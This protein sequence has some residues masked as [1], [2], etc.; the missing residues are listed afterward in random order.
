MQPLSAARQRLRDLG[1]MAHTRGAPAALAFGARWATFP[2]WGRLAR[3]RGRSFALGGERY[4]Y[5][6]HS[7]NLTWSNERAVEVP[8]VRRLVQAQAGRRVLEVG[9]VLAHYFRVTHRVVDKFER[10]A[11]VVNA[12]AAEFDTGERFDL[13]VSISTLEHVGFDELPREPD[14]PL[15]ALANLRRLLAPGGLL[16]ATLPLGY[17][18]DVDR[19]LDQR[20]FGWTR[21]LNLRRGRTGSD[22]TE[23]TWDEV[24]G[25]RYDGRCPGAEAV[26]FGFVQA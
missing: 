2:V 1:R 18:P 12:D 4:P 16:C 17:N 9:N 5:F 10:A 3:A 20:A 14:K 21:Q 13:I 8:V 11:G 24:R 25:S 15:R 7:Y 22:W 26:V 19:L 23:A 6:L